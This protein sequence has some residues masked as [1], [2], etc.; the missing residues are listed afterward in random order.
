MCVCVC[1]CVCVDKV[2]FKS[3][4]LPFVALYVDRMSF[5]EIALDD[6]NCEQLNFLHV[7][8]CS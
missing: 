2:L 7:Y 1:V 4:S 3:L 8:K 6:S 5:S